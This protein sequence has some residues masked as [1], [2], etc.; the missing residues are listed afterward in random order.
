MTDPFF[1]SVKSVFTLT[2]AFPAS[3]GN[4]YLELL[5]CCQSAVP[6]HRRTFCLRICDGLAPPASSP[7]LRGSD[8]DYPQSP[9]AG[10]VASPEFQPCADPSSLAYQPSRLPVC[11]FR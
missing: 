4:L 5:R 1:K 2:G 8:R 10:H 3:T 7:L 9:F 11:F 6:T